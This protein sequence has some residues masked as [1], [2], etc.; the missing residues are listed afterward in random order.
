MIAHFSV[1]ILFYV[2]TQNSNNLFI[3]SECGFNE[4]GSYYVIPAKMPIS[5]NLDIVVLMFSIS[6][7]GWDIVTLFLY[8]YKIKSLDDNTKH[9]QDGKIYTNE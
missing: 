9:S 8:I 2:L 6:V 7:L 4:D 5:A 3:N 1:T